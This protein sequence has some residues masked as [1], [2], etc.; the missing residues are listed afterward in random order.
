MRS[1]NAGAMKRCRD[2]ARARALLNSSPFEGER[3]AEKRRPM[4]PRSSGDRGGR[5]SARHMRRFLER[6]GAGPRFPLPA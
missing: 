2:A 5:L 3:R 4:D 6:F 1:G